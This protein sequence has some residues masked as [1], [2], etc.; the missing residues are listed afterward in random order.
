MCF[1]YIYSAD[2]VKSDV[3]CEGS[4]NCNVAL[5]AYQLASDEKYQTH[6]TVKK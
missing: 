1:I 6:S 2:D 3:N 5:N 4:L